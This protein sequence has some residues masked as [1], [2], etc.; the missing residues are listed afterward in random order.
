[1]VNHDSC[2]ISIIVPVYNREKTIKRCVDSLLNSDFYDIEI[3]LVD[4]GS[5]DKSLDII[6]SYEDNR[7]KYVHITNSGVTTARNTGLG[8]AKGEYVHF[9]DSDDFVEPGIYSSCADIVRNSNPDMILFDYNVFFDDQKSKYENQQKAIPQ[10]ILLNRDYILKNILPVMVNLDNRKELYIE[11]FVWNKLFKRKIIEKNQILFDITRR[12]WEDRLFQVCFL[13]YAKTLYY[14]PHNGYNYVIGHSSFAHEYDSSV[15]DII[16]NGSDDYAAIVG[17]LLEFNSAYSNNYYCRVLIDTAMQQFYL[18]K[19]DL[20]VLRA[21][22]RKAFSSEKAQKLYVEFCPQTELEARLKEMVL[23]QN[24]DGV[25]DLLNNE[26][27]K[28]R[29]EKEKT[30]K[31]SIFR[32]LIHKLKQ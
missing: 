14:S 6:R 26:I 22:I 18:E 7:V 5:T 2:L 15:F 29:L 12:R 17:D 9:V 25:F 4:D 11:S 27:K 20:N 3:I 23:K 1:M 24:S 16:L 13:K 30:K 28:R 19:I 32:K 10:N 21:D 31:K 8:I